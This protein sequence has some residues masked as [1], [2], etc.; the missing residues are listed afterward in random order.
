MLSSEDDEDDSDG[1]EKPMI[2]A[3]SRRVDT[4]ERRLWWELRFEP[5]TE[6]VGEVGGLLEE[7]E[8]ADEREGT[9]RERD[10]E[11]AWRE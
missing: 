9:E 2:S 3:D 8:G 1:R 4:E 11:E 7:T 6:G 10:I 5:P